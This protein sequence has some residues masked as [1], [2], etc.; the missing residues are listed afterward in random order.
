VKPRRL[1]ILIAALAL[2]AALA[3]TGWK[4][5]AAG[6]NGKPPAPK[7]AVLDKLQQQR[8]AAAAAPHARKH[9]GARPPTSCPRKVTPGIY[10][11]RF[12]PFSGGRNLI[13]VA[14]VVTPGGAAYEV[15]AGATDDDAE[16]GVL[17]LLS[18]IGDACA[19]AAG[20]ERPSLHAYQTPTRDGPVTITQV[21]G[22]TVVFQAA[23]G[24]TGR[25]NVTT[26]HFR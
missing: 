9:P 15:Y 22:T 26:A 21:E 13:N 6:G 25:F 8:A 2:A 5:V 17:I 19:A 1:T 24:T 18:D 14:S 12:G 23:N 7:Q 11:F 4:L 3:T 10:P 16:Q 20:K